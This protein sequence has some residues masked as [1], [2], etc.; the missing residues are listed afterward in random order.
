M[1]LFHSARPH[2]GVCTMSKCTLES[3]G[4]RPTIDI[5]EEEFR[6]I[7]EAKNSYG[8]ILRVE[9]NFNAV[10]EDYVGLEEI[11]LRHTL[12]YL[13]FRSGDHVSFQTMRNDINRSILHLLSTARLY[14]NALHKHGKVLLRKSGNVRA[15]DRMLADSS[16]Q[17]MSYRMVEALRNYCQHSDFPIS[18]MSAGSRWEMDAKSREK[19]RAAYYVVPAMDAVSVSNDRRT[20]CDVKEAL[21]KEGPRAPFLGHI[22]KFVEHLG[23]IHSRFRD[24][25]RESEQE[26]TD[27]MKTAIARYRN[28]LK[29]DEKL[30][31]VLAVSREKTT[32]NKV[33]LFD[34]LFEYRKYFSRKNGSQVNLSKRYVQWSE[35]QN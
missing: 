3:L 19:E 29:P 20:A 17:P 27:V 2:K 31:L 4:T 34:E 22:R 5:S 6:T 13:A 1:L 15:L 11:I 24:L 9:E 7:D 14:R 12:H 32:A 18:S 30:L 23:L 33:E 25:L 35:L 16:D 21:L 8:H 28:A 26:W 10:M